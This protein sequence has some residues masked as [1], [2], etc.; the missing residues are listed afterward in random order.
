M[1]DNASVT[2][3]GSNLLVSGGFEEYAPPA[4]GP[5]GWISDHGFRESPAKSETNQPRSGSK[6]GACWTAVFLDCGLYQDVIAPATGSYTLQLHA[7]ADRPG[8]LVGANVDGMAAASASVDA[9][10]FLNYGPS[11]KLS[12]TA[13]S[14][15]TI[16]VWMYSPAAPGYVVVDD[17]ALT[18]DRAV[19][20]E[21]VDLLPPIGTPSRAFGIN[22][23]GTVVGRRSV[24]GTND[25]WVP[26]A[27]TAASG[28]HDL[29][30]AGFRC[31]GTPCD[32]LAVN[33]NNEIVG[34]AGIREPPPG[35]IWGVGYLTAISAGPAK[36][37]N[38]VGTIVGSHYPPSFP[39][40]H[41]QASRWTQATG[42]QGF[43][44]PD[45]FN[46]FAPLSEARAIRNDGLVA[47]Y[48]DEAAV[49]WHGPGVFTVLG[50][51]VINAMNDESLAVG[52]STVRSG[53]SA[54]VW[55]D[56][57]AIE[58]ASGG[59]AFDVNEAGYV[60]GATGGHA[61]VWHGA[62]GLQDLG[63]GAAHGIDEAGRIVGWR[64]TASGD[65]ATAWQIAL[66]VEDLFV[67]LNTIA[68]RLLIGIDAAVTDEI[69]RDISDAW[70]AWT[71]GEVAESYTR[72]DHALRTAEDLRSSG[73]LPDSRAAALLSLG[74]TLMNRF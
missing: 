74:H 2:S 60:V 65:R 16:R 9:R 67:G 73:M 55:R 33:N 41:W 8:G 17:V 72:I 14:G 62:F 7:T 51:G 25:V 56:A 4:L 45:G 18:H 44:P 71:T 22:D 59:E 28:V 34:A 50:Q 24:F 63:P 57:T 31:F 46:Y 49:V 70:D 13:A 43:E 68:K 66:R 1:F 5:P 64:T 21:E 19:T 3:G 39:S 36:A 11:Y 42:L 69:L 29:G 48:R 26:F 37:I 27:W 61:F 38:D 52:T 12:F 10:G 35:Y 20:V 54:I 30:E 40:V 53:G 23:I 47:G 32:A 15:D 6:N 58:V